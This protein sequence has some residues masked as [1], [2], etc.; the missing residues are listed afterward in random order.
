M[1]KK[2]H[3]ATM[4]NEELAKHVFHPTV[5]KHAKEHVATLNASDAKP[6]KTVKK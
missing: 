3:P 5:L 1:R 6:K 4:T 2:K